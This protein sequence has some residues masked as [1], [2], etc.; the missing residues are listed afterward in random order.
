MFFRKTQP[1]PIEPPSPT[2]NGVFT[3]D[4]QPS[5]EPRPNFG[6]KMAAYMTQPTGAAGYAMDSTGVSDI[7]NLQGVGG[8]PD[9]QLGWYM[10][11]GWIGYQVS[12]IMAQ[13]WLIDRCCSMPARD[14]VRF[15]F[16]ISL[17][18]GVQNPEEI[19][20]EFKKHN[21]RFGI[22]T[23]MREL[24][25]MGRV[26]GVR[27]AIFKVQTT[28][29][30]YYAKPFNPD[31]VTA[32]SYLGISQVDPIWVVPELTQGALS[33]PASIRFYDPEFYT[34]GGTRYH[35]SHLHVYI[36]HPVPDTLKP[37]YQYGGKS[38]PQLIYERVYAAERTANEAPQLA[39]TK[40]VVAVSTDAEGFW[41]NLTQ[42]LQRLRDWAAQRD[43][44]GVLVLDK[45]ADAITQMDTSLADLDTVIMTQ[46][47]LCAAIAEVPATKL[48]GTAP[49]GFNSTGEYEAENYRIMLE[50]IQSNDLQPMLERHLELVWLSEIK[51]KMGAGAS[52]YFDVSWRPLDSPTAAEW[53]DINLKKAQTAQALVGIGAID[54]QDVREQLRA[55]ENNDFFGLLDEELYDGDAEN[56]TYQQA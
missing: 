31:G 49:K 32:G 45:Q 20:A 26:Y 34:I 25:H 43:N 21:R 14:A 13:H 12:A 7:K 22:D 5:S 54:G 41:A 37:R 36:P 47:Q 33:D 18:E 24:V 4:A 35:R 48:L 23:A 53:A 9:A 28:D 39:M 55:D 6:L 3:T 30:E 16:D 19:L 42:S 11:Q 29:K 8:A 52:L 56:P 1:P 50:S 10:G 27:V 40:R 44:Y 15:G 38:I 46:Y 17:D 51:P 2:R